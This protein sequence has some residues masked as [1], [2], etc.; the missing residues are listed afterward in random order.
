VPSSPALQS[1][2]QVTG[3]SS[4]PTYTQPGQLSNT[5]TAMLNNGST[6]AGPGAP[7]ASITK[8]QSTPP[9]ILRA[10]SN[11]SALQALLHQQTAL[12][13][14]PPSV[15]QLMANRTSGAGTSPLHSTSL[16][17]G[18]GAAGLLGGYERQATSSL[19]G[20]TSADRLS[21]AAAGGGPQSGGRDWSGD[22]AVESMEALLL[23]QYNFQGLAGSR[24]T[25][26][27]AKP[28]TPLL[29]QPGLLKAGQDSTDSLMSSIAALGKSSLQPS[30]KPLGMGTSNTEALRASLTAPLA[31]AGSNVA[32]VLSSGLAPTP[33]PG[34]NLGRPQP[35]LSVGTGLMNGAPG[36]MTDPHQPFLLG[37]PSPAAVPQRPAGPIG[38]GSALTPGAKGPGRPGAAATPVPVGGG[39]VEVGARALSSPSGTLA[40]PAPATPST[41][42]II[43]KLAAIRASYGE[44]LVGAL[45]MPAG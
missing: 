29:A 8:P 36:P 15:V 43:E 7:P 23:K 9:A 42:S 13:A 26:L 11:S 14:E 4:D 32:M 38:L 33:P 45:C 2:P 10:S 31:P 39:G 22:G 16:R 40:S 28:S 5:L 20:H 3:Q 37:P 6:L 12:T 25:G 41:Q 30:S 24:G 35:A 21:P 1:S 27:F 17:S 19:G 18:P 34:P 44:A